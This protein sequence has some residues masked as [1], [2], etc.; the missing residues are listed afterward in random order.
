MSFEEKTI[1]DFCAALASADPTP[2]GGTASAA[3]GALGASLVSM[4]CELTLSREKFK[5]SHDALR[6]ILAEAVEASKE[7][8]L[9]MQQDADAFDAIMSARRLPRE[10]D[11]EKARRQ[12]AITDAARL[13][14]EVPMRTARLAASLLSLSPLLAEK[15][16]PAAAS[17]VGVA[18]L[19]LACAA[20]GALLN[21]GINLPAIS[22]SAF[23]ETM[24]RETSLLT[25]EVERDRAQT[26]A[27]V[28]KTFAR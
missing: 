20:E 2:G 5:D 3:A 1:R 26:L 4:A 15:G 7:F 28:K 9:L 8:R 6:P 25:K 14:T 10:S 24:E 19:L 23:V 11:E 17:D 21:V 16:S 13:A 12:Q 27:L 18:G 22:D